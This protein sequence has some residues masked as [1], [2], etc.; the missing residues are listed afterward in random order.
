MA[1]NKDVPTKLARALAD[2]GRVGI[3]TVLRDG[4][5]SAAAIGKRLGSDPRTVTRHAREL[6]ALGFIEQ[7]GPTPVYELIEDA[8]F[9][10]EI[11]D[12]LPAPAK[13]AMIA[14][15]L[16][17][18]QATTEAAVMAGGFDRRDMHL[19]RTTLR[20]DEAAWTGVSREMLAFRSRLLEAQANAAERLSALPRDAAI[21]GQAVMMLFTSSGVPAEQAEHDE[22][23]EF[24]ADEGR[25]R[26]YV[27]YEAIDELLVAPQPDWAT[28]LERVDE[29]RVVV[30]AAAA[31][32]SSTAERTDVPR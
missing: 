13:Q 14:A 29:L 25:E 15:I 5:L 10:D 21:A 28:I 16:A 24:S 4:P 12:Q 6:S 22:P 2:P 17:Q 20:L 9:R 26:A 27:L 18:I 23:P 31:A 8:V 32:S 3:L 1:T 30:R 7:R 11:W 19:T